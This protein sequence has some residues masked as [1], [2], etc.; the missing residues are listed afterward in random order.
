[1]LTIDFFSLLFLNLR[2]IS[3]VLLRNSMLDPYTC[4]VKKN[5][6]LATE[7]SH[8]RCHRAIDSSSMFKRRCLNTAKDSFR[9]MT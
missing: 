9:D 5:R 1:M 3:D 4:I 8:V 6:K 2:L 7:H